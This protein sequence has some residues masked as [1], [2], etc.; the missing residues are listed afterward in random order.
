MKKNWI[1][2]A[3]RCFIKFAGDYCS[4]FFIVGALV[5]DSYYMVMTAT[6]LRGK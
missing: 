2:K 6:D 4:G 5:L 1:S 3:E